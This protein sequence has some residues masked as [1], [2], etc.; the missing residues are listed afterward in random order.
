MS[1][2]R[3][4]FIVE[5]QRLIAA[6]LAS[7]LRRLG[8]EVVGSAAS[9]EE[10]VEGAV[11]TRPELVLMDIRLEGPMDGIEAAGEL[12]RRLDVPIVYLT[13]Y[14]DEE[15]ILRAK[16]TGPFGYVVKPFNERELRAGI[17]VALYR[18]ETE[19][20]LAEER[21]QRAAAEEFRLLVQSVQDHAIIRLDADGRVASWNAGAERITGYPADEALGRHVELFYTPEDVAAGRP[22]TNLERA[23]REGRAEGEGWRVRRD[24][25]RFW[26]NATLT[27]LRDP[28]GRLRGFAKVTRDL[29]ERRRGEAH[30]A[31]LD[32]VTVALASSLDAD[33]GLRRAARLLAPGLGDW[34]VVHLTDDEGRLARTIAAHADAARA[35]EVEAAG[36]GWEPAG[37]GPARALVTGRP[38]RQPAGAPEGPAAL[39]GLPAAA[40]VS[41]PVALRGR[42]YGALTLAREGAAGPFDDEE[43]ALAEEVARRAGLALDNARLY[44]EAQEAIRARDEFL[45]VASHE[46]KTPLTPL[47]L[48]LDSLALALRKA[49]GLG[50]RLSSKVDVATR[51]T[52][53]LNRL[54]D[55]LLDVSRITGGRLELLPEEVDL[56]AVVR[57]VVQR[58]QPEARRVG[59]DLV[60]RAP[61]P[62]VG[63]WDRLRLEQVAC[64]LLSNALKY[65]AGGPVEVEVVEAAAGV[66]RLAVADRGIG[67]DEE[68]Q[69]RIFSRFERAASVRH[70]GG[71][72][73]GLFITRR[74]VEEHGG[75]ITVRSRPGEGAT[76]T[77]ELPVRALEG[78]CPGPAP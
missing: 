49:N 77:V 16:L 46:L 57:D 42:A 72:G 5:D 58:F 30:R 48:Q 68:G 19:R 52:V 21:A 27:P 78:A 11:R 73:L 24:G 71:L 67:I 26:A 45:Q 7:T 14:A 40:F 51:Q 9:G 32:Q 6:D 60:V 25:A 47:L 66:A 44:R 39:P 76:F 64:N 41:L 69:R 15:T 56:A 74:I 55:S 22:R 75:T 3:R 70:Y 28:D 63:W 65:G 53:R 29:T 8:Y 20:L 38:E 31:L 2:P 34:C 18:H 43:L 61:A 33:E 62:V 12:R 50:E 54:V 4:V 1:A 17:E 37:P 23:A 36:G 10:A 59:C 13:A 35:A